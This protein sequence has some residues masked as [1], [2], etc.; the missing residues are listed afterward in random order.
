V[1]RVVHETLVSARDLL[2]AWG[3][4]V[5]LAA[6][7]L[8]GAYALLD[9]TPPH[10]VV[11]AT[12]PE[13][14][15][16]AEFAKRYAQEL[17]RFG[18]AVELKPTLG[19]RDNL[20]LLRDPKERVDLAFVQG[21]AAE[22][23]RT[24]EEEQAEAP[25]VSLGSLF[26]EPVWIFYRG[27]PL[28]SLAQLAGRR[29]NTGVRGSGAPGIV[30]RLLAANQIERDGIRRS[31]LGDTEAVVALLAG[32]LDAIALVSAPES[33][34]VQM[35]LATPGVRLL[36][37]GNAE[38]YARRYRYISPVVLPRGV[39]D[40]ARDV[41]K[42]DVP[43]L[44]TTTSLVAR[45][46]THPALLELFVQAAARIHGAPGWIARAGQFPSAANSEFPLAKDAERFYRTGPPLLQR[47]LPFWLANLVDRMWVALFSIVA[48]LIPLSRLLPPLY[49]FRVRSRIFRWYRNLRIIEAELED[50]QGS[51]AELAASLDRLETRAA[52]IKVPLSYADELYRLRQHIRLVRERLESR[53]YTEFGDAART[54]KPV[55]A[56]AEDGSV[57]GGSPGRR[58]R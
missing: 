51:R 23:V 44:A 21:G 12:G 19:S 22:R 40:L 55:I 9:P 14:T 37:F 17:K 34:M 48:V 16:Y 53:T 1:P 30:A 28:A 58:S 57:D 2:V 45:E 27:Q 36:E 42:H 41:P 47:Y 56:A 24:P 13:R 6:A 43:L 7:L 8:A 38:A 35:L 10:R 5:L 52:A 46:D 33:P 15:A 25:L 18:I 29:V 26:Y 32:K 49:Q 3:P 20:R 4:F 50:R 54:G 31:S 11:L 39:A